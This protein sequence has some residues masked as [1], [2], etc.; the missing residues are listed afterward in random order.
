MLVRTLEQTVEQI[1]RLRSAKYFLQKDVADKNA[2]ISIDNSC[3]T[4]NNK[5][6]DINLYEGVTQDL[7]RLG[8]NFYKIQPF[9]LGGGEIYQPCYLP[10]DIDAKI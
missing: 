8:I 7:V 3:H 4:L 6:T 1:R 10:L 2:A 5:D 9:M